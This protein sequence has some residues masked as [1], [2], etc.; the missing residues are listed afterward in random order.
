MLVDGPDSNMTL[1]YSVPDC[2]WVDASLEIEFA[3]NFNDGIWKY[4]NIRERK[5]A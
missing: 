5:S 3:Q 1:S 4:A 2:T